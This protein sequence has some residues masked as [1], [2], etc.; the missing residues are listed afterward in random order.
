MF[1]QQLLIDGELFAL[2]LTDLDS[3]MSGLID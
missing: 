2:I 3:G 1:F